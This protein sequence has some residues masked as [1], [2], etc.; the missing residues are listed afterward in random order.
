MAVESVSAR[1]S[2]PGVRGRCCAARARPGEPSAWRGARL[3]AGGRPLGRLWAASAVSAVTYPHTFHT[4]ILQK[5][6][7][8]ASA[9][10]SRRIVSRS[11]RAV[12]RVV[13]LS[14]RDPF[15]IVLLRVQPI[16]YS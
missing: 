12:N 3:E 14:S 4:K 8:S 6:K 16:A 15:G 13:K 2:P 9:F 10:V 7:V 5:I 1:L 11:V